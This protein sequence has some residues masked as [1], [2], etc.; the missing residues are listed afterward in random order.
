MV[1]LFTLHNGLYWLYHTLFESKNII[2]SVIKILLLYFFTLNYV[3]Q[4]ASIGY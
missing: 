4:F 3:G 2:F 1:Y